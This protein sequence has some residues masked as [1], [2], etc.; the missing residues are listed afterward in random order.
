[1]IK[2]IHHAAVST[3]NIN[4][5]IEFYRDLLGFEVEQEFNWDKGSEVADTITGLKDSAAKAAMLLL[6][7]FRVELFEFSSPAP[8]SMPPG[9]P[10][11]D[12]GITHLAFTVAD[13]DAEY[14]RLKSSGMVF[15]CP[16]QSMGPNSR[17]TYGR[18]PDGN[19]IELMEIND[20]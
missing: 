8:R 7:D 12:H 11:C 9:R 17:V 15:H 18:D 10:V 4:R 5:M 14:E 20:S 6:G 3:G 19:V 1:M 2:K 13:I 16:P